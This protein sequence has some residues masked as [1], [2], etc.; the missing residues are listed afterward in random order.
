MLHIFYGNL[1]ENEANSWFKP[2]KDLI[3]ANIMWW[4]NTQEL[5]YI[6]TESFHD[7]AHDS[8]YMMT[9]YVQVGSNHK[10][11]GES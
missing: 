7:I 1:H 5:R 3:Y 8:V 2:A 6:I 4:S 11:S 10:R 9:C